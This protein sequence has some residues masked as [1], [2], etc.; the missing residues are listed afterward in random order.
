MSDINIEVVKRSPLAVGVSVLKTLVVAAILIIV[1]PNFQKHWDRFDTKRLFDPRLKSD[2]VE[3]FERRFDRVRAAIPE[4]VALGYV[5]DSIDIGQFY[6][7]QYVMAP[8]P[9]VPLIRIPRLRIGETESASDLRWVIGVFYEKDD[10]ASSLSRLREKF[11]LPKPI[12]FDNGIYLF[13]MRR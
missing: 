2:P 12:E 10:D 4:G 6:R 1:L 3:K 9:L 7:T 11:S 5:S 8:N 13:E